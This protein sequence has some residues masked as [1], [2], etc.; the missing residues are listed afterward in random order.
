MNG[1]RKSMAVVTSVLLIGSIADCGSNKETS[2]NEK[3]EIQSEA[4]DAIKGPI[5]KAVR[6]R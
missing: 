4:E 2:A 6:N 1:I 3:D 5:P